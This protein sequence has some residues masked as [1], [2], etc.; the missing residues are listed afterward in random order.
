MEAIWSYSFEHWGE[1]QA[2]RYVDVLTETF[3]ALA[4][5]TNRRFVAWFS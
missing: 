2:D 5:S 4:R 1:Q 3:K